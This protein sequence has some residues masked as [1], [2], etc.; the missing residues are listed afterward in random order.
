MKKNH[1]IKLLKDEPKAYGGELQKK[2]AG[3][4][5]GRPLDTKN[6]MHLT[7]RSTQ[8]V[9]E[10]SF[11]RKNNRLKISEITARFSVKYGVKILSM[12]NV[13][14]HLHFQIKLASRHT[15]KKFIRAVSSAIVMAITGVSRLKKLKKHFWNFRPF[16]RIV[17]GYR[18]R[19]VLQNYIEMNQLEGFG[20][21]RAQAFDIVRNQFG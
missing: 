15:Y 6:T 9:G 17:I 20:W 8:A 19:L 13:G 12:A 10:W 4:L 18:A 2:R 21:D 5:T 11:A 7:L 16:T 1:Q 14:N 3:R